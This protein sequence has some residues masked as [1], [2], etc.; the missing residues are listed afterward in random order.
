MSS[1]RKDKFGKKIIFL[2]YV[3][4]KTSKKRFL[5]RVVDFFF[6]VSFNKNEKYRSYFLVGFLQHSH[7]KAKLNLIEIMLTQRFTF[8]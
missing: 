2:T 5:K 1:F 4:E 8:L 7:S 6:H 3:N